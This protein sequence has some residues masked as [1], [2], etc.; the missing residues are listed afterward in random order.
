MDIQYEQ[1]FSASATMTSTRCSTSGLDLDINA[2]RAKLDL[3][4]AQAKMASTP[5]TAT[6]QSEAASFLVDTSGTIDISGHDDS[7]Q[8][9]SGTCRRAIKWVPGVRITR[10][11]VRWAMRT[12]IAAV[13]VTGRTSSTSMPTPTAAPPAPW[14]SSTPDIILA[15][16]HQVFEIMPSWNR[17][18]FS[19]GSVGTTTTCLGFEHWPSWRCGGFNPGS[20]RTNPVQLLHGSGDLIG[21]QPTNED[22]MVSSMLSSLFCCDSVAVSS[23][24]KHIHTLVPAGGI[25]CAEFFSLHSLLPMVVHDDHSST[26]KMLPNLSAVDATY[27]NLF[28]RPSRD[29]VAF[30]GDHIR[31]LD[32]LSIPLCARH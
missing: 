20:T 11:P 2:M 7:E 29:P 8:M 10:R 21:Q 4:M 12:S 26:E 5:T 22:I 24:Y 30:C 1:Q 6:P 15:K 23:L 17:N 27:E 16:V 25:G 19:P 32:N 31:S 3:I 13:T 28:L 14:A 18:S 9:G